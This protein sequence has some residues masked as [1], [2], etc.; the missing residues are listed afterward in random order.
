M[1]SSVSDDCIYCIVSDLR[2]TGNDELQ[3]TTKEAVVSCFNVVPHPSP[4]GRGGTR[5]HFAP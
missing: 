3:M 5:Q 2:T 1:F 4:G